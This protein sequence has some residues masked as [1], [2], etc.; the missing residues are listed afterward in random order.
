[1][2]EITTNSQARPGQASLTER[3]IVL[4][5]QSTVEPLSRGIVGCEFYPISVYCG[6]LDRNVSAPR[7]AGITRS[8][9]KQTGPLDVEDQVRGVADASSLMP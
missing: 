4:R 3:Q 2:V 9:V 5:V 6:D 7:Q 1:M 8:L